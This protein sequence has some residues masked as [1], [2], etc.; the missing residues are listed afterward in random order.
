MCDKED[1]VPFFQLMKPAEFKINPY[2]KQPMKPVAINYQNN[3]ASVPLVKSFILNNLPDYSVTIDS[4]QKL[5]AF[6][7]ATDD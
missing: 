2:T 6:R 4:V 7:D 3:Q 5:E 1:T